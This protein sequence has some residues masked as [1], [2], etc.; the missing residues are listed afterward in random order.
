MV[1]TGLAL[2]TE[3]ILDRVV[4]PNNQRLSHQ[5]L[6]T[7]ELSAVIHRFVIVS[8]P[9]DLNKF[10]VCSCTFKY[11]LIKLIEVKQMICNDAVLRSSTL[12]LSG[13]VTM[14]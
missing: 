3:V 2:Q 11:L 5:L 14:F 8:G 13:F 9:Q 10:Q 6:A 12:D 4:Q 7:F 1:S